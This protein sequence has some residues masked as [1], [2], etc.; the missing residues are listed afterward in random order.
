MPGR[1]KGPSSA[2]KLPAA[3][4]LPNKATL[5]VVLSQGTTVEDGTRFPMMRGKMTLTLNETNG[6][7]VTASRSMKALNRV[8]DVKKDQ[9]LL[10][11]ITDRL[12]PI[13]QD[14]IAKLTAYGN[15]EETVREATAKLR[16]ETQRN[17]DG[18]LVRGVTILHLGT[19][20]GMAT[21]L[22][23]FE[24]KLDG[25]GQQV[26]I[27]LP[28]ITLLGLP[29]PTR[30]AALNIK[31]AT[32][33]IPKGKTHTEWETAK[34]MRIS[35]E[36]D[37]NE[38]QQQRLLFR[39]NLKTTT[40]GDHEQQVKLTLET[41]VIPP[42]HELI[43]GMKTHQREAATSL[44]APVF[45]AYEMEKPIKWTQK[46]EPQTSNTGL[47][48]VPWL[49]VREPGSKPP[50]E[51]FLRR[52]LYHVTSTGYQGEQ[53]ELAKVGNYS[54][55]W[56]KNLRQ[57]PETQYPIMWLPKLQTY[58]MYD[59]L[60][61]KER[62]LE[63]QEAETGK[64]QRIN[65]KYK[66]RVTNAT[67]YHSKAPLTEELRKTLRESMPPETDEGELDIAQGLMNSN[68]APSTRKTM[69]AVENKL[70]SL[71]PG[72]DIFQDPLPGDK[73]LLIV[74]LSKDGKLANSTILQYMRW[75][76]SIFRDKGRE[77]PPETFHY[78]RLAGG[79]TKAKLDPEGKQKK[80]KRE[81]YSV[82]K[83]RLLGHAL[84]KM[85][86]SNEKAWGRIQ[87]QGIFAATL[88]AFWAC[89]RTADLCGAQKDTYSKKTT[90][91]ERDFRLMK[92]D[93]K[94]EG[95]EVFFKCGKVYKE[96]GSKVQLPMVADG[97]LTDLCPVAAYL[98]YQEAK[99]AL[100]PRQDAPWLINDKGKPLTQQAFTN[101]IKT[102]IETTY[103][104][105]EIAPLMEAL[106]GHSFRAALPTEI[107]KMAEALT[108]EESR[109]MG[110]W[111]TEAAHQRYCKDEAGARYKVARKLLNRLDK[112]NRS[113][114]A[115]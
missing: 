28:F 76:G 59:K 36:T 11:G 62:A 64:V 61:D 26:S 2:E 85:E 96:K 55:N 39:W 94:V 24:I 89:A 97:N 70:Q 12:K 78:E 46:L 110:R 72:R 75:Y 53:L 100:K 112:T 29:K 8:P 88:I 37:L 68:L 105:T 13:T 9:H 73:S 6:I 41:L 50:P 80:T 5:G 35:I 4:F 102:A 20:G 74:R 38:E 91:L 87:T 67:K 49:T 60:E 113:S 95:L 71:I 56:L 54:G 114:R 79:V 18:T 17:P 31:P 90:L 34:Q 16:A 33:V 103:K 43:K 21:I 57:R 15:P 42:P 58:R 111:L 106:K 14:R 81:A 22:E 93:G 51:E 7:S 48:M 69:K 23:D 65:S 47:T 101:A 77:P 99:S 19:T 44:N 92:K 1:R 98:Q 25:T 3:V 32:I 40:K 45:K 115:T 63:Q 86:K 52:F 10:I 30:K 109:L 107:Q 84:S 82:T 83:L 66:M 104:D 108:P 27:Q